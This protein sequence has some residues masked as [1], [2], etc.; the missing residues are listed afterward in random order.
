MRNGTRLNCRVQRL[1]WPLKCTSGETGVSHVQILP[2][3]PASPC[4]IT[5]PPRTLPLRTLDASATSA[6]SGTFPWAP[7]PTPDP[8]PARFML[9]SPGQ[10]LLRSVSEGTAASHSAHSEAAACEVPALG[11]NWQ[12]QGWLALDSSGNIHRVCQPGGHA[13]LP[14]RDPQKGPG[15]LKATCLVLHEAIF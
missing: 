4:L 7:R 12:M 6:A 8:S 5:P 3:L 13:P 1:S 9:P 11:D 2:R 14:M 15:D 10:G